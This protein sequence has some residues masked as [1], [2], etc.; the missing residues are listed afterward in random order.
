MFQTKVVDKI[1][2]HFMFRNVFRKSCRLFDIVE[3]YGGE[4]EDA[5]DKAPACGMLDK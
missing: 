2:T 1:K 4:K 5:E 3:K